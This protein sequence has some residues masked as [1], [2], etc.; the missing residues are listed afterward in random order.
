MNFDYLYLLNALL[1]FLLCYFV[2][3]YIIPVIKKRFYFL[4]IKK[5]SA[6]AKYY[7]RYTF[8]LSPAKFCAYEKYQLW[9]FFEKRKE[10]IQFE[11]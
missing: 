3:A 6:T 5:L 8:H 11:S 7:H 1:V 4:L 2:Y 10:D 9:H